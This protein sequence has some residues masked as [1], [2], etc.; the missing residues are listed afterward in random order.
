MSLPKILI[1]DDL[2]G[3][4]ENGDGRKHFCEALGL[5]GP[6]AHGG[7]ELFLAEVQFES[8]QLLRDGNAENDKE[9]ALAAI[10]LGWPFA[11]GSR[12]ALICID[13][14]FEVGSQDHPRSEYFGAELVREVEARWR[15]SSSDALG[16][17]EIPVVMLSSSTPAFVERKVNAETDVAFLEKWDG[18]SSTSTK[19]KLDLGKV[20]FKIG[21]VADGELRRIDEGGKV[22]TIARETVILGQDLTLLRA[23]REARR[24]LLRGRKARVLL[25][26]DRGAGKELFAKYLHD[27]AEAAE[28]Y[29]GR[30]EELRNVDRPFVQLNLQEVPKDLI[31]PTLK[32]SKRGSFT[33]STADISGFLEEAKCGTLHLDEI[34]NLQFGDLQML[35]RLVENPKYRGLGDKQDKTI[36]CHIVMTTNKDV[37]DMVAKGLFPDDLFDRLQK[38]TIPPLSARAE[39]A[40]LIFNRF[41]VKHTQMLGCREKRISAQANKRIMEYEW[42][43]NIR[44]L[45]A[46][47]EQVVA[48]REYA[49]RI[50]LRDI[51]IAILRTGAELQKR[52][53]GGFEE[54]L[55]AIREYSF[56]TEEVKSAWPRLKNAIGVL[57]SNMLARAVADSSRPRNFKRVEC[58]NL[59]ANPGDE[60]LWESKKCQRLLLKMEKEYGLSGTAFDELMREEVKKL[61][62]PADKEIDRSDISD[63]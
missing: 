21:L 61:G 9:K 42:P 37:P 31:S 13:L 60:P 14:E 16:S 22:K 38:L 7:D 47:S 63:S 12:W 45:L 57:A 36:K 54:L 4:P 44:Q 46:V 52:W 11:D 32:G 27:H 3:H 23:L 39:D 28:L 18:D 62:E 51:D 2:L 26:A 48:D 1:I 10:T 53:T 35:L 30:V 43:G 59:V 20:L 29:V 49:G 19:F 15:T 34:G 58:V 50:D 41:V 33:G 40:V 5:K 56:T 17:C 24:A 8:G 6:G 25:M 55:T